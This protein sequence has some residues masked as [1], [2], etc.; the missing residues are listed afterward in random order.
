MK[1]KDNDKNFQVV[2]NGFKTM[3]Q[4]KSFASWYQGSGEQSSEPWLEEHSDISAAHV[5]GKI[6]EETN[7]VI[8]ELKLYPNE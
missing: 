5:D 7:K 1:K 2:F 4:A 6:H 8:I 3:E